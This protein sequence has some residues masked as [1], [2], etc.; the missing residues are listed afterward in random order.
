MGRQI[1][2]LSFQH[3]K[4]R[5]RKARCCA[6]K[7]PTRLRFRTKR[8]WLTLKRSHQSNS[9]VLPMPLRQ[10]Q[11][12]MKMKASHGKDVWLWVVENTFPLYLY[13]QY[14][15]FLGVDGQNMPFDK[16]MMVY[17]FQGP[18]TNKWSLVHLSAAL[19]SLDLEAPV[20]KHHCQK[21]AE[22]FVALSKN[23]CLQTP[24]IKTV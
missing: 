8:V 24:V 14:S 19:L 9:S 3:K 23:P 11:S 22:K 16:L 13:S 1:L 15:L 10:S 21:D 17:C 20:T 6:Q 4:Y 7:G 2:K 12:V 18:R 5:D